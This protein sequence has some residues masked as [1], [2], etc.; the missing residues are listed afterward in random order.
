VC[1]RVF[2]KVKIVQHAFEIIYLLTNENPIQVLVK[3]IIN[4]GPREDTTRVGSGT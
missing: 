4:S 1:A 2:V 3:A